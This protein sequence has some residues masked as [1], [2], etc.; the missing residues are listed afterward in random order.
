MC[1]ID[2][3][4]STSVENVW[5]DL[6]WLCNDFERF[7]RAVAKLSSAE[8]RVFTPAASLRVPK[9]RPMTELLIPQSP[10]LRN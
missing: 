10:T 4:C 1:W 5:I 3:E 8:L 7:A 2:L 6:D 9:S